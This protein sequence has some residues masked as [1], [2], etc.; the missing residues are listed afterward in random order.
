MPI[1]SWSDVRSVTIGEV[2]YVGG[3]TAGGSQ[4]AGC[5]VIKFYF[6]QNLWTVLPQYKVDEFA[7]VC[8]LD[9]LVLIGGLDP[10]KTII[11]DYIAMFDNTVNKWT[12][13]YSPLNIARYDSTAISSNQSIVVAGGWINCEKKRIRSTSVEVFDLSTN[14]WFIADSLPI[15]RSAAKSSML[16]NTLYLLG[17]FD[18]IKSYRTV[19]KVVFKELFDKAVR[20]RN[21]PGSLQTTLWQTVERTP[22]GRCAALS[23]ECYLLAIG[24]YNEQFRASSSIHLLQPDTMDWVKVGDLPTAQHGSTCSALSNGEFIVIG[25]YGVSRVDFMSI[26]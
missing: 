3:S 1:K 10:T 17:G 20:E 21:N 2:V 12:F 24:G 13:P 11:V 23:I 7:M 9:Q 19:H 8:F 16:G 25:G 22:L 18:D 14:M 4:D 5:T 26:L 15:A 6:Q